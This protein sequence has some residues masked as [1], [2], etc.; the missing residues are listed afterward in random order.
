MKIKQTEIVVRLNTL[1]CH[2][3]IADSILINWKFY[4]KVIAQ[5]FTFSHTCDLQWRAR[6]GDTHWYRTVV[7]SGAYHHVKFE[8]NWYVSVQTKAKVGVGL[9]YVLLLSLL[10]LFGVCC[11]CCCCAVLHII[12][13]WIHCVYLTIIYLPYTAFIQII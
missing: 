11:C 9:F 12:S 8:R 2:N 13:V 10:L 4:Q 3:T 6:S 5:A 1:T 7:I